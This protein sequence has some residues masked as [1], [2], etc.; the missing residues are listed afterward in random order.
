[1]KQ[2]DQLADLKEKLT[3]S[4]LLKKSHFGKPMKSSTKN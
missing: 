1:M 4:G 2:T 3:C